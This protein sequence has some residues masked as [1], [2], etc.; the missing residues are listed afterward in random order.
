MVGRPLLRFEEEVS[1]SQLKVQCKQ[2]QQAPQTLTPATW[3]DIMVGDECAEHRH[4]LE[5]SY[6]VNNGAPSR[7]LGCSGSPVRG[8]G[9]VNNWEEMG[10]VWDHTFN[11]RLRID[12][13]EC[14]ILLTGVPAAPGGSS[15]ANAPSTP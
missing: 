8:T 7:G 12:P 4:N 10:H 13:R 11:D 5:V 14:R 15:L 6:P 9:V 2:C 1:T 3:Q